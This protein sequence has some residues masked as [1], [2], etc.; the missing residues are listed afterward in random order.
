MLRENE[1]FKRRQQEEQMKERSEDIK[2]ME[3]YTKLLDK[4]EQDRADYFKKCESRQL[5]AMS[6]MAETVIKKQD[7]KAKADE[8]KMLK[9]QEE[10]EKR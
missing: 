7:E 2:S 1:E 8:M 4:Q 5:E 10:K 6:K 3:E 9:Y